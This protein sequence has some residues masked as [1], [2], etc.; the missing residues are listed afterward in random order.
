MLS[1]VYSTVM[2][3]ITRACRS[4]TPRC[5]PASY[6]GAVTQPAT[7]AGSSLPLTTYLVLSCH[8][9]LMP[10]QR[11]SAYVLTV[12]T[13]A[14]FGERIM[15]GAGDAVWSGANSGVTQPPATIARC[16]PVA[17]MRQSSFVYGHSRTNLLMFVADQTHCMWSESD[18]VSLI[19]TDDYFAV[20]SCL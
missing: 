1:T 3:V 14:F 2:K 11:N 17:R 18:R 19:D 16:S 13:G 5:H 6:R 9:T 8:L 4:I 7:R 15:Q 12:F 20:G 10:S